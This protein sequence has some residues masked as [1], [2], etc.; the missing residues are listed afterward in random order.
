MALTIGHLNHSQRLHGHEHS[1]SAVGVA[2]QEVGSPVQLSLC[3]WGAADLHVVRDGCDPEGGAV[4]L[5]RRCS[6]QGKMHRNLISPRCKP[7]I[8]ITGQLENINFYWPRITLQ[9]GKSN[10]AFSL[11]CTCATV[12][13]NKRSKFSE[14]LRL[15]APSPHRAVRHKPQVGDLLWGS[16]D[17]GMSS[18]RSN[19]DVF[20]NSI[21]I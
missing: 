19:V 14:T 12:L 9:H 13:Q 18:R 3:S 10:D 5:A 16:A 2:W 4:R 8:S 15:V 21:S 1:S 7:A 11:A 20:G 6:E 17:F